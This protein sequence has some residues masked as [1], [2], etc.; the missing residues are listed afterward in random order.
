[1]LTEQ[2]NER[3]QKRL[4]KTMSDKELVSQT[5]PKCWTDQVSTE[6]STLRY[7]NYVSGAI[8]RRVLRPSPVPRQ[9]Y[10]TWKP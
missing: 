9:R 1:M 7:A 8:A 4:D 2:A 10:S 6:S 5:C 3:D